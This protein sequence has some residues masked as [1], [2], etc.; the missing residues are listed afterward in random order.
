MMTS[1][2]PGERATSFAV[3][4]SLL[5]R[6]V[7]QN[8]AAPAQLGLGIKGELR[9]QAAAPARPALLSVEIGILLGEVEQQRT[10]AT[11]NLLPGADGEET[12]RKKETMVLFPQSAG[13]GVKDPA[14]APREHLIMDFD[15]VDPYVHQLKGSSA[16]PNDCGSALFINSLSRR[17]GHRQQQLID[18]SGHGT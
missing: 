8:G 6:F 2:R 11:I 4:C 5:S 12:E 7:R 18:I 16:R 1:A 13:F 3:A 10:P 15:K 14:A 9:N 17:D